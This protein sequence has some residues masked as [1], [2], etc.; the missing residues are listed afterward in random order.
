MK[1]RWIQPKSPDERTDTHRIGK[2]NKVTAADFIRQPVIKA[3]TVSI[4]GNEF[5]TARNVIIKQETKGANQ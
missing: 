1:S 3:T 4:N 2:K 5:G